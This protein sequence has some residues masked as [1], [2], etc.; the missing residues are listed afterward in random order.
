MKILIT[1]A[2][3]LLGTD[4]VK[5]LHHAGHDLLKVRQHEAPGFL[6]LDFMNPESFDIIRNME[7]DAMVHTAA[8]KEPDRCEAD[9]EAAFAMNHIA[10]RRLAECCAARNAQML[11]I[12]TDYVFNGKNPPYT[13]NDLPDPLNVY[14]KSKLAGEKAVLE[15]LPESGIVLRVPFLFGSSAGM[16]RCPLLK[17]TWNALHADSPWRMDDLAIRYPTDTRQVAKA[18][19]FLLERH[20]GGIYHYSGQDAM[21]RYT[22]CRMMAKMIHRDMTWIRRSVERIPTEA[23]RPEKSHLSCSRIFDEGFELPPSFEQSLREMLEDLKL[24]PEN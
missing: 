8:W 20:A 15:I 23:V 4:T 19:L 5:C 10:T 9:P 13:E 18:I 17:T 21:T 6:A 22:I 2:A 7:W 3:G 1:G 12:S 11:F 16:E 24:L 14:G